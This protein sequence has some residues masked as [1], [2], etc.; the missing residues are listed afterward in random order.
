MI[1]FV[2]EHKTIGRFYHDM[3]GREVSGA[4]DD[5]EK[6]YKGFMEMENFL[7]KSK[8]EHLCSFELNAEHNEIAWNKRL[9]TALL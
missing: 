9:A 3:G 5:E 1:D 6:Y 4:V 7:L 8:S 2:N